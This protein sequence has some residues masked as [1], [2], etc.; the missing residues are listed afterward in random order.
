MTVKMTT[1]DGGRKIIWWK[2][3]VLVYYHAAAIYSL[4]LP[5]L[6]STHIINVIFHVLGILG[7]SVG[8]HRYFTHKSFKANF[9]LRLIL[10]II[11]TI[12]GQY[13]AIS[14]SRIHRIHHKFVDTDADP[15][16]SKR[17]FFYSHIGWIMLETHPETLKAEK[18]IDMSDLTSDP[19]LS[20]QHK[21]YI[22]IF[23]LINMFLP[24]A[25]MCYFG[26]SFNIAW[27]ANVF[28]YLLLLHIV[29]SINSAAH[30]WGAKPYDKDISPTNTYFISFFNFGEGWHNYHHVR[31]TLGVSMRCDL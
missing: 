11:Q 16:N 23:F 18:K 24:V 31:M 12:S 26:E 28:R 30:I 5:K 27:N 19:I 25:I 6:W 8:S 3:F 13:S 17:G 9:P 29:F 2:V 4:T 1:G 7:G 22:P 14:W 21:F 15:H 10:V 20:F